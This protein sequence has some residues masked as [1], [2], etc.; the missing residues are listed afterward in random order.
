MSVLQLFYPI[1]QRDKLSV[2]ETNLPAYN[3]YI[4]FEN[5]HYMEK[6]IH[7]GRNV[8]R[9]REMLGMKQEALAYELGEEWNQKKVSLLEQKE[10]IEDPLLEQI[11]GLLKVLAEAIKNFDEEKVVHIISN[12]F[13][14][15]SILNGLNYYPTFNPI[16]KIVELY[17][18]L[19][20]SEKEKVELLKKMLE[21]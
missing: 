16:E 7:Q 6:T 12:T 14:D 21:K 1:R 19:V 13:N 20:A 8:K 3:D 4:C 17:E 18:K 5:K 11:A 9:F 2:Y 15:S 10:I